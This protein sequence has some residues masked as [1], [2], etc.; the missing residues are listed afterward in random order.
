MSTRTLGRE[1]FAHYLLNLDVSNFVPWRDVPKKN[2]AKRKMISLSINPYDARKWLGDC[3]HSEEIIGHKNN[4]LGRWETWEQ[5][6]EYT[7]GQLANSYVEWQKGVRAPVAPM[8]TQRGT[9]G[10]VLGDA[11]IVEKRTNTSRRRVL[12]T[13]EECLRLLLN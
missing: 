6:D 11:G 10:Q 5:G 3:A 1:A 7:F 12:P 9:L 4:D 2:E 13:P 8:P